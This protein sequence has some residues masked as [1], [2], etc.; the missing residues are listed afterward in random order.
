MVS[1]T[2]ADRELRQAFAG[3]EIQVGY[4]A[5]ETL[6]RFL[7]DVTVAVAKETNRIF[8]AT[9]AALTRPPDKTAGEKMCLEPRKRVLHAPV[10]QA[11][12]AVLARPEVHLPRWFGRSSP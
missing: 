12:R 7:W 1:R 8:C 9:N 11:S 2:F 4:Q 5:S 10:I 6:V 3:S